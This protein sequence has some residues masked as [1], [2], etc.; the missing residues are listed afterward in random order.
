MITALVIT[1]VVGPHLIHWLRE[2]Q[3]SARRSARTARRLTGSK[4]GT[5]TMGG[6]L[7]LLALTL[8]TLLWAD[9]TNRYVCVVIGSRWLG[10]MGLVDD[11]LT[12][13]KRWS[14]GLATRTKFVGQ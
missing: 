6:T 2:S 14:G 11:Y 10:G 12:L 3:A 4:P 5:P 1:F 13:V 9:L 7:I 8:A